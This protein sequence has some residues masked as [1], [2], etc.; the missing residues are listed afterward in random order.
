[1]IQN[2]RNCLDKSDEEL[3][4]LSLE[5]SENFL[6]L[7]KR[8]EDKIFKFVRRISGFSNEEI[9]DIVQEIFL[10]VYENLNNFDPKL[11]FSSWIYRIARN[12][13]IDESRKKKSEPK[14]IKIFD[15]DED[16]SFLENIA[17]DTDFIEDF[18][19]QEV[20]KNILTALSRVRLE[21]RE[22]LILRF[23]EDK[24]YGEISD[25]LKKPIGTISTLV[26]RAK[27]ELRD[28]MNNQK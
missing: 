22:V 12:Q 28:L 26:S 9:E 10:K 8:F 17:S 2:P 5:N 23:F 19:N 6:C 18:E 11:K 1:M 3:V 21:Y 7:M 15:N 20:S 13:T 27:K 25:I 16:R 4:K 24:D 14:F